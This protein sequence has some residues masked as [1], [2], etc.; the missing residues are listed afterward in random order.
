MAGVD[1]VE[2][3]TIA[4]SVLQTCRIEGGLF[5]HNGEQVTSAEHGASS[6]SGVGAEV[7]RHGIARLS[8][9]HET[10]SLFV[11]CPSTRV[12]AGRRDTH[13]TVAV[14]QA[15]DAV[16]AVPRG[17]G[18]RIA[19]IDVNNIGAFVEDNHRGEGTDFCAR[20]QCD[21][22]ETQHVAS[23]RILSQNAFVNAITCII[24]R[25]DVAVNGEDGVRE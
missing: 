6:G 15:D 5:R 1:D 9:R 2:I 17:A 25:I 22:V 7:P 12:S 19:H 8:G 11:G 10:P 21:I 23:A 3:V 16:A 4:G 24:V 13:G 18:W 20:V 14:L